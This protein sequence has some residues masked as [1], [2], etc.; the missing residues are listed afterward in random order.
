MKKNIAIFASGGG[1]NAEELIKYF[2]NSD[3]AQVK[4]VLSNKVDAPVLN[5]AGTYNVPGVVFNREDFYQSEKVLTILKQYNIDFIVLAGFLWLMPS[6]IIADFS[7]KI[8]NIHPAL[9]PKYGGKGMYGAN[10][11][12]AVYNNKEKESGISIHYVNESYD[13]G[14]IIFQATC[15]IEPQMDAEQIAA[16]VLKLEHKHFAPVIEKLLIN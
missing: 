4:L 6:N 11:H 9:L 15:A 2:K 14:D 16:C 3:L 1:S 5:K 13:E 7:G 10:V 12:Q 8:V